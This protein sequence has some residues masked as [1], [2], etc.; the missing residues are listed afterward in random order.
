MA[1]GR[2]PAG[3]AQDLDTMTDAEKQAYD[4]QQMRVAEYKL[5]QRRDRNVKQILR[6]A[7]QGCSAILVAMN[8]G[9]AVR[10][11]TVK[12]ALELA[13]E[14]AKLMLAENE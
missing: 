13:G 11:E 14:C 1:R 3:V 12:A 4:E 8:D 6:Q 2:K 10:T 9:Y 7:R 5:A